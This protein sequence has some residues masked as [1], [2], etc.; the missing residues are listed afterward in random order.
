MHRRPGIERLGSGLSDG[1]AVTTDSVLN[2]SSFFK[3]VKEKKA[4]GFP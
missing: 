4:S 2:S 3:K 1:T